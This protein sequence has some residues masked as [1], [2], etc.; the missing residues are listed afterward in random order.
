MIERIDVFMPPRSQYQVLHHFTQSLAAALTRTGVSCRVLE[1]QRDQPQLFIDELL[2]NKPECTLSFNGLLP[3]EEGR[4][5]CNLIRIPHVACLVDA[6]QHYLALIRSPYSVIT[7]VD[8]FYCDFFQGLNFQ[9]SLFMPHGVDKELIIPP[10]PLDERPFE[11]LMLA[12]FIDYEQVRKTWKKTFETA[13]C[14]ALEEA[15]EIIL[16]ERDIPCVQALALALDRQTRSPMGLDPA[17]ID[18]VMAL[19]QLEDYVNGR[20][21]VDLLKGIKDAQVHVFGAGAEGWKK[22]LGQSRNILTHDAVSYDQALKLMRQSKVVLNSCPTIKNGAH[23]RIFAGIASGAAVV[24]NDNLYMH[25]NFK[26]GDSI[27]FYHHGRWEEI[28]REINAYLH[29]EEKRLVLVKNGQKIVHEGHTWDH[30]A[31]T[32]ISELSPILKRIG[33][34]HAT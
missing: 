17:K 6:P 18:F 7:C 12:S 32:L 30:R 31:A 14:K 23:E 26:H 25:D 28:N 2:R 10:T 9:N 29:D 4:F 22:H 20:D 21:R 11:A 27:L 8:R 33:A 15:A 24:T 34:M 3:D 19:D 16:S 1:A 5:F 13:L